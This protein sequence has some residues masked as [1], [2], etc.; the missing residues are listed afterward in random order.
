MEKF[1]IEKSKVDELVAF[2][3]EQPYKI[4]NPILQFLQA[5]LKK[6]EEIPEVVE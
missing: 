3:N 5:N 2:L 1:E 4:S 6:V